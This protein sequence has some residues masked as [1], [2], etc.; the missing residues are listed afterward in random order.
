[1]KVLL[2]NDVEVLQ[3]FC[4]VRQN[5]VEFIQLGRVYELADP[6]VESLTKLTPE[7]EIIK[8]NYQSLL[9][10]VVVVVVV[11]VAVIVVVVVVITCS[12]KALRGL[13]VPDFSRC[14]P[15]R[16]GPLRFPNSPG[17]IFLCRHRSDTTRAIRWLPA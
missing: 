16:A 13:V 17:H 9:L 8:G 4:T 15:N 2:V 12:D 11:V 6:L 10:V 5:L 3:L 14:K 7:T 1:M